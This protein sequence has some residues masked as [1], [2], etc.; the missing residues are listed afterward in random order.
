MTC[1]NHFAS[2]GRLEQVLGPFWAKKGNFWSQTSQT[3]EGTSQI[4]PL[5]TYK[6]GNLLLLIIVAF[7]ILEDSSYSP[8]PEQFSTCLALP[9]GVASTNPGK[10]TIT[11]NHIACHYTFSNPHTH[12]HTHTHT[13][14]HTGHGKRGNRDCA[15][16]WSGSGQLQTERV[17]MD[18]QLLLRS[19]GG[20]GRSRPLG[21]GHR[22]AGR[23][24]GRPR[25]WCGGRN[26]ALEHAVDESTL[27]I[28]EGNVDISC[29]G[30]GSGSRAAPDNLR[31]AVVDICWARGKFIC[32][33]G[34]G[35]RSSPLSGPPPPHIKS[36]WLQTTRWDNSY[37]TSNVQY[38]E[39]SGS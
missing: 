2:F 16:I 24:N 25:C 11:L 31:Q 35:R 20:R 9:E 1:A 10:L 33:G 38:P 18:L 13:N 5:E 30:K 15:H 27:R 6:T 34:G 39:V 37:T 22:W 12:T 19:A 3:R 26:V 17:E 32:W 28:Q 4:A 7:V 29:G 21:L 14:I 8:C 23:S 36:T